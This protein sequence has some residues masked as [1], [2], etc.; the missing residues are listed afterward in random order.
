MKSLRVAITHTEDTIYPMHEFVCHS[1]AVEREVL[2]EGK[3]TDGVRT[4]VFYV[5]GDREAY[6]EMLAVRPTVE[7]YDITPEDEDGFYLYVRAENREQEERLF[8]A[9]RR[10]TVVVVPPIEFRSDMSMHLTLIGHSDDLQAVLDDLPAGMGV[11]VTR[12]GE[13]AGP[14]GGALTDRQREALAAAWATGYYEVPREGDIEAVADELDC[15]R[16][17]A[18]D[19]LRRAE[20]R[21]VADVLGEQR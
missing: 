7:E 16:S 21:L 17:T 13:Y 2:L 11:D 15:A 19:L 18:S 10:E 8:D 1:P 20:S 9:F 14:T 3:T 4:M 5:E 12:I 6:E